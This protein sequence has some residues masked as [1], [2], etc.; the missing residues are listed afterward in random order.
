M[1]ELASDSDS[2]W[3]W[4]WEPEPEPEPA[5]ASESVMELA[6]EFALEWECGSDYDPA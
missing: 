6:P 5:S 4:E 2:E 1:W 3:E